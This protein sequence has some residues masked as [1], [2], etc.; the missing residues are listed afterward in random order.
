MNTSPNSNW[1]L[2]QWVLV[3]YIMKC[4]LFRSTQVA[5]VM[6]NLVRGWKTGSWY[7]VRRYGKVGGEALQSCP[8]LPPSCLCAAQRWCCGPCWC[9]GSSWCH[10]SISYRQGE[11]RGEAAQMTSKVAMWRTHGLF[12]VCICVFTFYGS[13]RCFCNLHGTTHAYT[14]RRTLVVRA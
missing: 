6:V 12:F 5:S 9:P 4:S 8:P 7:S 3:W 10:P 13:L 2:E 1:D 11:R 14:F